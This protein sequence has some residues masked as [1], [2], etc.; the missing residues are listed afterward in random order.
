MDN[1]SRDQVVGAFFGLGVAFDLVDD[2]AVKSGVSDLVT[3]LIGFISRHQWSPNDDISNTFELRPEEL[4]MLLQVARHV[5]PANTVSGPFIVPPV[6]TGVAVDVLSNSSYFK[7]NLDY[8]SFY[9]LVRLQDNGDNRGAY[10]TVRNYTASH[11]NAFFNMIDR[12]L[13]G[14]DAAR[15][16]ETR[17]LLDQ[18][19]QRPKRDFTVDVCSKV[20]VCG[21]E[22]CQPVP[23]PL[24]PPATFLWEVDPFQL[25]GRRFGDHRK[26]GR[27]LHS[28]VLDGA[29]L[30]RDQR[31]QR[32]P[33]GGG[34]EQ[35]DRAGF[36]GF[37]VRPEPGGRHGAGRFTAAADVAGRRH[38]GGNGFRRGAAERAAALRFAGPDQFPGAGRH[39]CRHGD[40]HSRGRRRGTE[41]HG[42][43]ASGGAHAVQHERDRFGSGGGAGGGGAGRQ[44]AGA[45]R[46][47]RCFSAGPRVASPCRSLWVWTSRCT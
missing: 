11:Q 23:V 42:H 25:T 27:G 47:C 43:G 6:G 16:A 44:S 4:Q 38:A 21:S 46:R 20:A 34:A 28:A 24:R 22:A 37:P 33:I 7:F 14:P 12:A 17:T 13:G 10:Q 39:G 1:T 8:M 35:R 41:F 45:V 31:S 36:A 15:D 32:D 40:F 26:R 29:V 9:Q 2:P 30:R 5:N 19:L 3:L 18:W